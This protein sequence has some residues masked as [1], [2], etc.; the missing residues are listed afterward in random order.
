MSEIE[1]PSALVSGFY[2]PG[3]I[4]CWI[5]QF[6]SLT[7]TP[8]KDATK[9]FTLDRAVFFAYSLVATVDYVVKLIQI[10]A[11][12]RTAQPGEC[13]VDAE[14]VRLAIAWMAPVSIYTLALAMLWIWS[15]YWDVSNWWKDLGKQAVHVELYA[16]YVAKEMP[17]NDI[18]FV[19]AL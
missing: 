16:S 10:Y 14:L 19:W 3:A 7:I 17:G 15:S 13:E 6:I 8:R 11:A 1:S 2:G 18:G 5:C 12:T 9:K 4:A